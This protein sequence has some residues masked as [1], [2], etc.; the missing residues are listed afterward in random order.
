MCSSVEPMAIRLWERGMRDVFA[1]D[2]G[3]VDTPAGV[4]YR[5]IECNPRFNGA[6]YPTGVAKKLGAEEWLA[7]NCS[8]SVRHLKDLDLRGLEFNPKIKKG[9]AL[10]NWG[11]ILAGKLGVLIAGTRAE[12]ETLR[13]EL[14]RRI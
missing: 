7:L 13:H 10:V 2:V 11:S 14:E 1:F 5:P 4:R 12:Q 6:S 3:V 8:T 9:I